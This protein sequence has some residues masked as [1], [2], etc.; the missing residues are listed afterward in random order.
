MTNQSSTARWAGVVYLVVVVSGFF[1]LGYV[2]GKIAAPGDPQALLDN[3][4]MHEYLFRA[5]I[6]SFIV[7]QVAFLLLPL[8]LFRLFV[9]VHRGASIDMVAFAVTAVPI[10]LV[11]VA[12]RLDA[13]LFLTD[14]GGLP[15]DTAHALARLSLKAWSHDIFV[16][17]VFWG[18]WLFPFGWLVI[19]SG[20]LPRIL[21]V[22]LIL[23]GAG[24]LVDVGAELLLPGY[25]QT[26]FSDYVHLPAALGEVAS[27]LWLLIMGVRGRP[28][29]SPVADQ[30][31]PERMA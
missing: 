29:V 28:G 31:S 21:G 11:G 25:A 14:A 3:I 22:L 9:T 24:Y 7:E 27:C 18:L 30:L 12:H 2:P 8:L 5:G 4:V 19:R 6:A 26:A 20:M 16:A 1:S 23:G 10:A 17:S 15:L 13:L